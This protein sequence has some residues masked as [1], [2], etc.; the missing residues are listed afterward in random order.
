M[1]RTWKLV[2]AP[3]ELF[4]SFLYPTKHAADICSKLCRFLLKYASRDEVELLAKGANGA[5]E[6]QKKIAEEPD[7]SPL[8]GFIRHRRRSIIVH[9]VPDGTSRVLKGELYQIAFDRTAPY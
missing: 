3:P 9:Y 2:R 1:L 8:Y 7:D 6:M 5:T 4:V